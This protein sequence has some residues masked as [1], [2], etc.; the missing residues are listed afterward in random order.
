M[1]KPGLAG[2]LTLLQQELARL[3]DA[4]A[5]QDGIL[6]LLAQTAGSLRQAE[7][8]SQWT[9]ILVENARRLTRC[10]FY[11][12]DPGDALASAPAFKQ[13]LESREPVVCLRSAA[14]V[15]AEVM[16]KFEGRR[17]HLL[18]LNGRSRVLGVLVAG[19]DEVPVHALEVLLAIAAWS[20]EGREVKQ[21]ASSF[22]SLQPYPGSPPPSAV[23]APATPENVESVNH[24][25]HAAA[26]R[27]AMVN[28]A[29]W[30]LECPGEIAEGRARSNLY[31]LLQAPIDAARAL[32]REKFSVGENIPDFLHVEMVQTL[33]RNDPSLLGRNYPGPLGS[34]HPQPSGR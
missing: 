2:R 24:P 16:E 19:G 7:S 5:T 6:R 34:T 8:T 22:I 25:G 26:R 1:I 10:E 17:V 11:R 15:T 9:S 33:A 3:A 20:L 14:Q 18:P 28:V 21:S 27:F 31:G 12:L 13:V 4:A 30:M 32:Y 23:P 29:K